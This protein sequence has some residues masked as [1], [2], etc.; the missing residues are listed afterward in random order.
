M[1]GGNSEK[2]LP[3]PGSNGNP[4]AAN[5]VQTEGDPAKKKKSFFG[6]I[7][8]A[9]K[10]DSGSHDKNKPPPSNNPDGEKPQ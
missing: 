7:A 3:P 10:G 2:P 5:G 9:F 6:K 1:F 4:Q 8:D